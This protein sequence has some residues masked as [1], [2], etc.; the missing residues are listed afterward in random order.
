MPRLVGARGDY[1]GTMSSSNAS[2]T[3]KPNTAA[4][5]LGVYLPAT[6]EEFQN[7]TV[8]RAQLEELETNP[9]QWLSELRRNGPHPRPVVA[10]RLNISIAGL[11]RGGV[12]DPLT[13]EE[14]NALRD[15][16]PAW[17]ERERQIQAQVRAED[18]RV[19]ERDLKAAKKA[20]RL[21]QGRSK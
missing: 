17:L 15:E 9:P 5:R 11:A 8:T 2:Q 10:G 16:P 19:A 1:S 3:M 14:I 4:K 12:T 18:E 7:S 20:A 6:P 21:E 13:T